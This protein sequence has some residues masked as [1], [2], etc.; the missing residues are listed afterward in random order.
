MAVSALLKT[1]TQKG[2]SNS[3]FNSDNKSF[4]LKVLANLIVQLGITYYVM[5]NT[6]QL[7][8]TYKWPLIIATFILLFFVSFSELP[9]WIKGIAFA[10]FSFCFGKL[11]TIYKKKY[12]EEAINIAVMG[13]LSVFGIMFA[14]GATLL[15]FGIKLSPLFGFI[16]FIALLGL[17]IVRLMSIFGSSLSPA[18]KTIYGAGIVIFALYIVYDTN[19]ILRRTNYYNG[20]FITASMD[21]YL[22]I[23]NL[24]TNTLGYENN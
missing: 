16:L 5:T 7:E 24:F 13:A 20:D 1:F 18:K 11:F 21:Y 9:I 2:G 15:T 12:G 23:I 14:I 19:N 6:S 8:P 22:D 10:L 17:I 3:L 4:L